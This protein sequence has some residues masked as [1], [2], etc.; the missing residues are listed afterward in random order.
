MTEQKTVYEEFKVTGDNVV[1]KV[2]EL[3]E[4]GNVSRVYLKNEEGRVLLEIP[5]TAGVAITVL[6]GV[7]AP[8]LVAVGAVSAL[9][10]HVTVGVERR[11]PETAPEAAAAGIAG[12]ADAASEA[13][14]PT[15]DPG[16]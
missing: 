14:G 12:D 4:Q 8:V 16:I 11:A 9:L 3:I 6:T 5:L 2:R 7:F 13:T 10:T 15:F 1:A